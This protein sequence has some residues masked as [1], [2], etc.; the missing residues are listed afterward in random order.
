MHLNRMSSITTATN[1]GKA[2]SRS[3]VDAWRN[4]LDTWSPFEPVSPFSPLSMLPMMQDPF[5]MFRQ[6]GMSELMSC[7]VVESPKEYRIV[8]ELPGVPEEQCQ[9]NLDGSILS[10]RAERRTD[11]PRDDDLYHR[12]EC[13]SGRVERSFDIPH[14]AISDKIAAQFNHGVLTVT[15]PRN[16]TAISQNKRKVPISKVKEAIDA[17]EKAEEKKH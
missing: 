9:I 3:P 6:L 11:S 2:I 15:I 10:I 4:P 12:R 5:R 13:L 17:Q 7:D 16:Q 1:P 14:D 8:A